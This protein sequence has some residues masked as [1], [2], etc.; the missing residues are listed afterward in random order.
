M[1]QFSE[2]MQRFQRF[3]EEFLNE[4]DRG[5]A[6]LSVCLLEDVLRS[7]V[8]DRIAV[9]EKEALRTIAPP[10][11]FRVLASNA[12]SIGVLSQTEFDSFTNI[13]EIRNLFAHKVLEKLRFDGP[14]V[15]SKIEALKLSILG[16]PLKPERTHRE[17][18]ILHV[19]ILYTT[20]T[21]IDQ[22][23]RIEMAKG[24]KVEP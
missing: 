24:W 4:S 8:A 14:E 11:S 13:V 1:L 20:I 22:P 10:G 12:R 19:V 18:F 7:K 17:T 9:E 2:A 21:M 6:V 5:V 16:L 23:K 15:A 3:N